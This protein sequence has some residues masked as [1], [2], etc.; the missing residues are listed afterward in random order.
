[1]SPETILKYRCVR[2]WMHMCAARRNGQWAKHLRL[3]FNERKRQGN[4]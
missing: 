2:V 1:M 3:A 4:Y